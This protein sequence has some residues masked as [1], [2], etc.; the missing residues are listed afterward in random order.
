MKNTNTRSL[1]S[2]TSFQDRP[3]NATSRRV[4]PYG[5]TGTLRDDG[6]EVVVRLLLLTS[7][8][9]AMVICGS[10]LNDF[11]Q[12]AKA[13]SSVKAITASARAAQPLSAATAAVCAATGDQK[14]GTVRTPAVL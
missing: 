9:G 12:P 10:S 13:G 8:L 7:L 2:T 11:S 3:L 6:W 4:T 14:P 5:L 1:N